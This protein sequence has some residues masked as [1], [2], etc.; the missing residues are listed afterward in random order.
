[1]RF[2][3]VGSPHRSES[4]PPRQPPRRRDPI[5]ARDLFGYLIGAVRDYGGLV[6]LRFGRATV[7]LVSDPAHVRHILVDN[8]A[9]Y[10]K[11][12]I[13]RGNEPIIGDGL[14]GSDGKT[15]QRQRRSTSPAF[16]RQRLTEMVGPMNDVAKTATE[17]WNDR[18]AQKTPVDLLEE[19][20]P[21]RSISSCGHCSAPASTTRQRKTARRLRRGITTRRSSFQFLP[22]DAHTEDRPSALHYCIVSR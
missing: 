22:P 8:D 12:L 16:H 6:R 11:V 19:M 13:L 2:T 18:V 5:A 9:N 17:R 14:F 10:W 20:V 21:I 7:Y 4:R 3:G 1:M 15:W